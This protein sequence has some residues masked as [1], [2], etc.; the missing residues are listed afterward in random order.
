MF[1]KIIRDADKEIDIIYEATLH[2][3]CPGEEKEIED[4]YVS[5]KVLEQITKE[6][7]VKETKNQKL[8]ELIKLFQ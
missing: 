5:D 2:I 3:L 6:E 8:M 7:L 1:S 4:S